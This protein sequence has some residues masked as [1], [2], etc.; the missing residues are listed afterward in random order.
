MPEKYLYI[1]FLYSM[2]YSIVTAKHGILCGS[3]PSPP[4]NLNSDKVQPQPKAGDT[5]GQP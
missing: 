2:Y 5:L 1:E 4:N 3:T